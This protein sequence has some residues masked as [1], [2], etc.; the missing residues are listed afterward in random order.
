[1]VR[2]T[3]LNDF[4]RMEW[5]PARIG[6]ALLTMLGLVNVFMVRVNLSVAIV[7]MV[8][9]N[10]TTATTIQAHCQALNA[11][12]AGGMLVTPALGEAAGSDNTT[13]SPA[14][15]VDAIEWGMEEQLVGEVV[16]EVVKVV[17]E[18]REEEEENR[19]HWNEWVQGQVLGSF[20]YGYWISQ[21]G[22]GR[23][24]EI[25]GAKLIFGIT[26]LSGGI[27][28][29]LTPL[30]AN[31]HYIALVILRALQGFMQ[32]AAYPCTF[33]LMIRWFP[34]FEQAKFIAFVLF[35]NNISIT[36][37]MTLCGFVIEMLGW[38][39]VFYVTGAS[40]LA[41][42]ILWYF[43]MYNDPKDHPRISQEELKY[44]KGTKKTYLKES[45][46]WSL[47]SP[48]SASVPWLS[49][50]KSLPV[51]AIIA[52]EIGNSFGYTVYFSYLPTYIE[53]VVG[54]SLSQNGILSALPFL[55]RYL[56]G[57]VFSST[58]ECLLARGK[59]TVITA[60]RAFSVVAMIGPALMLLAVSFSGCDPGLA[61][62]LLC[63]G[64]FFN[65]AITIGVFANKAEVSL[66]FAGTVSGLGNMS[67]NVM[68]F[69]VP[70]VVGA[71]TNN[72]QTLLA[73]QKV[74]WTCIPL[75]VVCELF[76]F[77]FVSTSRQPWD[78][79]EGNQGALDKNDDTQDKEEQDG[80]VLVET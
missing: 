38:E 72:Q 79:L 48:P 42:C 62:S 36:F 40:S 47:S 37:T 76:F 25:Y 75:Y 2:C 5:F 49:L 14:L 69:V 8:H 3:S 80:D 65:G 18:V 78:F 32:G 50:A 28:A 17:E 13:V 53:N 55:A 22:G 54:V 41:W 33:P 20:F 15:L 67:A 39:A 59:L 61:V 74:F 51:W 34:R 43:C 7:G 52:G 31:F 29:V 10:T 19:M 23:L 21:V 35:C 66:H 57:V 6:V 63:L 12:P 1:M 44:I 64:F 68:S 70:L 26:V 9:R 16:E 46:H 56:G 60:R 11:T 71:I 4:L 45:S 30:T 73:W 24:A 27:A 77:V 58:G